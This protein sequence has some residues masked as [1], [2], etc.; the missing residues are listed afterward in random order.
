MKPSKA[1]MF[2]ITMVFLAELVFAVQQGLFQYGS[3][4][5]SQTFQDDRAPLFRALVRAYN[6]TI[7]SARDCNDAQERLAM[8][9]SSTDQQPQAGYSLTAT[10]TL[11]C[12]RWGKSPPELPPLNLSVRINAID[13]DASNSYALYHVVS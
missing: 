10:P 3:V 2:V 11:D 8:L 1:Q 13:S 12:T 4:D 7:L 6:Q 9:K 5:L